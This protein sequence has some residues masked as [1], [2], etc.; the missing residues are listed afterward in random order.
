MNAARIARVFFTA[1][2]KHGRWEAR[3]GLASGG[4]QEHQH[5]LQHCCQRAAI[6]QTGAVP[7]AAHK[8]AWTA[9]KSSAPFISQL[10]K[11]LL[12]AAEG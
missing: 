2:R 4:K 6:D 1:G 12:I 3:K 7:A 5:V 11:V 9:G 10:Q 8:A